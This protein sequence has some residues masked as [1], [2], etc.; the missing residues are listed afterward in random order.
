MAAYSMHQA[1]CCAT[2]DFFCHHCPQ[3][4]LSDEDFQ[5]VFRMDR[6][7]FRSLQSWKQIDLKKKVHLF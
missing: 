6:D 2:A 5:E 3:Q 1:H 7:A 4:H